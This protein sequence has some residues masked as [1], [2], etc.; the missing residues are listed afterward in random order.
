MNCPKCNER[1]YIIDTR[2][3][4]TKRRR[5]CCNNCGERFTTYEITRQ[6][7]QELIEFRKDK[8]W[9]M[10]KQ[11]LIFRIKRNKVGRKLAITLLSDFLCIKRAEAT[12]I[13]DE[14]IE[15]YEF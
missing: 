14:E 12:R 4:L 5:Y 7:Y 2:R 1:A 15:P 6:D 11:E 9:E 13:Y 3:S 8:K 10:D